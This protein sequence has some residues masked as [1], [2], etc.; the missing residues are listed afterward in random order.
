MRG[1][2]SAVIANIYC[3][4]SPVIEYGLLLFSG[5][6]GLLS[7]IMQGMCGEHRLLSQLGCMKLEVI[8]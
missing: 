3:F 8:G 4:S 6:R 7:E 2:I 1:R 5:T